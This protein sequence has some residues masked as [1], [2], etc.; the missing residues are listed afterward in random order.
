M[1]KKC[2]TIH[3]YLEYESDLRGDGYLFEML[4]IAETEIT[5]G[6]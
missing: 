2:C 3:R 1:E 5:Q 6:R 4:N